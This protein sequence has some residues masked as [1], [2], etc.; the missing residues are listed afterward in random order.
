MLSSAC[1]IE[2]MTIHL[3]TRLDAEI[4]K[5]FRVLA[6]GTDNFAVRVHLSGEGHGGKLETLLLAIV[7][8]VLLMLNSLNNGVR[9]E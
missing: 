1:I 8:Q 9:E 5:V 4:C 3:A 7:N 2:T 6:V